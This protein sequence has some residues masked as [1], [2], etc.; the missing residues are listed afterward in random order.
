MK[1]AVLSDCLRPTNDQGCHGLGRSACELAEGFVERGHTVS[2]YGGFGSTFEHGDCYQ[3]TEEDSRAHILSSQ[4]EFADVVL[5]CSHFHTYSTLSNSL[6]TINSIRDLEYGRR[7]SCS[8]NTKNAVVSTDYMVKWVSRFDI[9]AKKVHTGLRLDKYE[10]GVKNRKG[11]VFMCG[12]QERKGHSIVEKGRRITHDSRIKLYADLPFDQYLEILRKAEF[13]LLPSNYLDA[14]PRMALEAAAVGT[15]TLC[16]N[17]GGTP[18]HVAH[19]LTGW[20]CKD[21]EEFYSVL[22]TL[23]VLTKEF[24]PVKMREWVDR[25]HN[26]H[27]MISSYLELLELVAGGETW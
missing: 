15:P 16:L 14:A 11:Y 26:Y 22:P 13:M 18:C 20:I 17:E 19:G 25:E 2:L 3:H 8:A 9:K 23:S 6:P 21:V 4:H 12:G 24:E 5:D 10:I 1:I 27:N 7:H